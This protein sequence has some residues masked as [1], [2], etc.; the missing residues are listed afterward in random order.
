MKS[1]QIDVLYLEWIAI[2]KNA[3]IQKHGFDD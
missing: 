3:I 2:G 1:G